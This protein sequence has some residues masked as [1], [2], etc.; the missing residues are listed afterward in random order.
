MV[1]IANS[2][3]NSVISALQHFMSCRFLGNNTC[4]SV[5]IGDSAISWAYVWYFRLVGYDN[6][7]GNN[8]FTI[9]LKNI[10][11][12]SIQMLV[13]TAFIVFA[14][15]S[16]S[17]KAAT[18]TRSF[19]EG[20]EC[21]SMGYVYVGVYSNCSSACGAKGYSSYCNGSSGACFCK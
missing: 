21:G 2:V 15:S 16:G 18:A 12:V 10:F 4:P 11:L 8:N 6:L 13:L 1:Y 3:S 7:F 9:M 14:A 20:Y 5:C 19:V 17:E